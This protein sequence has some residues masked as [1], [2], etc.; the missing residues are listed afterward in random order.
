MQQETGEKLDAFSGGNKSTW[1]KKARERKANEP[2]LDE[3]FS[4]ALQVIDAMEANGWSQKKL[5]EMSGVTP[6]RISKIIAGKENL[7]L[8]TIQDLNKVLNIKIHLI[9]S[10]LPGNVGILEA[11]VLVR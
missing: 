5:A 7:T 4:I 10:A 8:K 11:N 1:S 3:S 2:W 9:P 6:Q